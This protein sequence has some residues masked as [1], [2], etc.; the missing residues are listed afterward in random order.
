MGTRE[1]QRRVTVVS[2]TLADL[3]WLV[4][5]TEGCDPDS[6]VEVSGHHQYGP[7]ESE[8]AQIVVVA[9]PA[10]P[11]RFAQDRDR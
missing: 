6:Q 7:L 8:P 1:D 9:R 10:K 3:R 11:M 5:Q 2:P 4:A